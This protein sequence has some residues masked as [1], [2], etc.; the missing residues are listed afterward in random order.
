M[1]VAK[2]YFKEALKETK[3]EDVTEPAMIKIKRIVE[4]FV[5]RLKP[6]IQ[7]MNSEELLD[8]IVKIGGDIS[9]SFRRY[10]KNKKE[11][12]LIYK[13]ELSKVKLKNKYMNAA[14]DY[15][16]IK[17]LKAGYKYTKQRGKKEITLSDLNKALKRKKYIK[18][19]KKIKKPKL[20][21]HPEKIKVLNRLRQLYRYENDD[22]LFF[23]IR[24][25]DG[26]YKNIYIDT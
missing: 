11:N 7:E 14:L 22:R 1:Y 18:F 25:T 6:Q 21:K 13:T 19:L 17:L 5:E 26:T 9:Q 3:A 8:K 24:D 4:E 23:R 12:K 10:I 16:T 20:V 15:I 2:R